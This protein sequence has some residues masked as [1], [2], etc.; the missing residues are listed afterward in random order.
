ML[1]IVQRDL[2][3]L[4]A[5]SS[6]EHM[7]MVATGIGIGVP[8]GVYGA[9]LHAFNHSAAKSLLFFAAGNVRE[10]FGTLKL[11]KISGMARSMRWTSVFLGVGVLAIVGMPPFSLFISEF[12]ILNA[13]FVRENHAMV[14]VILLALVVGFGALVFQLQRMLGGESSPGQGGRITRTE[15]SAM[16]L[17][18][19]VVLALG[20]HLPGGFVSMIHRAMTV[21]GS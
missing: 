9:L 5:Y 7:G 15:I 14:T 2:K 18:A 19:S 6:V 16:A 13:A 17:C 8:L 3:R 10:N 1:M 11:G 20:L 12:A 4:F 21:L